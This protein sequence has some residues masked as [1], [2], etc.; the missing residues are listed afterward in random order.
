M[1][2]LPMIDPAQ[3]EV[4]ATDE[5]VNP[6]EVAPPETEAP[7]S[8]IPDEL[9]KI[10]AMAALLAGKPGALSWRVKDVKNDSEVAKLISSNKSALQ[11]S[12]I[13]FYKSLSGSLGVMFN[14]LALHPTEIKQADK[15][16]KLLEIAPPFET[17]NHAM[18]KAGP[19]DEA[20]T[21]P[22]LTTAAGAPPVNP[23]QSAQAPMPPPASAI[24]KT[25]DARLKNMQGP[26][27]ST[28][29]P[30]AGQGNLLKSILRPPL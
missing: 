1:P 19:G 7:K 18:S 30:L 24:K 16:G 27:S 2:E 14:A 22:G 17:V 23:P 13:G 20:L 5:T 6:T 28:S 29:G 25:F 11:E 26:P 3:P 8:P 21:S 10:P 15:A 12:G 9:L 4:P